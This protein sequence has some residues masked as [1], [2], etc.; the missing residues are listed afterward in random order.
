[1][2]GKTLSADKAL[3]MAKTCA[4]KGDLDQARALYE[5]VLERFPQNTRAQEGLRTLGQPQGKVRGG[6]LTRE[7]A[8]AVLA[9]Y[10]R[11]QLEEA[12]NRT[13]ALLAKNPEVAFLHNMLGAIHSAA[14]RPREAV[15]HYKRAL[16]LKPEH[17]LALNNLASAFN[18][19]GKPEEAIV[20][21]KKAIRL[22]PD[23]AE[24]HNNLG[25]SLNQLG[26]PQ[27]AL[28]SLSKAVE[29][30]PNLAEAHNNLGNTL[31]DVG[32]LEK[33]A[34][35]YGKALELSPGYAEV[36][37]N[38]ST[39]K[40][41]KPGDPQIDRLEKLLSSHLPPEDRMH[42]SFAMAKACED[43]GDAERA[44]E[45]I[46]AGNRLRRSSL[47][48]DI[49]R[50]E[51]L[52]AAIKAAFE[53]PPGDPPDTG[54]TTIRPIFILGMPRS[55]TSLVEQ[56]LASHS[57]VHGGGELQFMRR[58]V[59]PF[60]ESRQTRPD[61]AALTAIRDRYL[62][63]I[64]TLDTSASVVTDKMPLNFRWTGFILTAFPEARV[65]HTRRDPIATG[66]SIF[67]QFFP[68]AGLEFTWDLE[69][70][71]SYQAL[72]EELMVF[73]HAAFPGRIHDLDYERLT[74][75]Q[76]AE[77]R[78]LLAYC[79]LEWEDACLDFHRTERAVRTASAAQVRRKMY[80]GS[81][82][83]WRTHADRLA[84]LMRKAG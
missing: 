36:H 82:D 64:E 12:L 10:N 73:W 81:S 22:R 42:L 6:G 41:F 37:R 7:D 61:K 51:T 1:M 21:V 2:S 52:F 84:P 65:I 69:D 79:G 53:T 48:Y 26:R 19:L 25:H 59:Q 27:E 16:S 77:T 43:T 55:G 58:A 33:A 70:I 40:K 76:E 11:G 71:A 20:H 75:D 24:A 28:E 80:K 72:Y 83:A 18:T 13:N 9:L 23:F 44:F 62:A 35:S 30:M 63:D 67:K 74:E 31:Q 34:E 14:Q 38:L 3:R 56:I 49:E 50:D 68:A 29:L 4:K 57:Q 46:A 39:I 32:E 5:Q 54:E 47:D 17:P 15:E 66:W 60:L 78:K 8:D 45:M